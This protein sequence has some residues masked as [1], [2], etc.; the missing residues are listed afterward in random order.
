VV[1]IALF[2]EQLAS[3]IIHTAIPA[4]AA[5]FKVAPL[6][7]GLFNFSLSCAACHA[8]FRMAKEFTT[9]LHEA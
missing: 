8:M 6:S 4:M 2:M 1:T 5:S 9:T 3:T 7:L